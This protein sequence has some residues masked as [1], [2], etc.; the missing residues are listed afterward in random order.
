MRP[1]TA[2]PDVSEN[3]PAWSPD[4]LWIAYSATTD[5][6]GDLWLISPDGASARRLTN[7]PP[8]EDSPDWSP[9]G[10][11]IA[12]HATRE[13]RPPSIWILDLADSSVTQL[14]HERTRTLNPAWS[15]NGRAITYYGI[16]SGDEQV[17][18]IPV[19]GGPARRLS[20]HATQ[21]W[22]ADWSPNGEE[23]VFSGYRNSETGGSLFIMPEEGEGAQCEHARALTRRK[24]HRWDREPS[25]SPDGR[26]IAFT[27]Q[28]RSGNWDVWL[29]SADGVTETPVTS[30]PAFDR[31]PSWS[32]DSR[33]LVIQSD[34][35]GSDDLWIVD[36]SAWTA[37]APASPA[38]GAAAG[39]PG[40]PTLRR[41]TDSKDND[42]Q[43]R[44]S[45]DGREILFHSWRAG[46]R[47]LWVVPAEGGEPQRLPSGDGYDEHGA[48]SPNGRQIAFASYV[49]DAR[50]Q[51]IFVMARDGSTPPHPLVMH[52]GDDYHPCWSPDGRLITFVTGRGGMPDIWIAEA[53]RPAAE[54]P[55]IGGPSEDGYPSWFPRGD[56]VLFQ[57]TRGDGVMG[58][59][60]APVIGGVAGEPTPFLKDDRSARHP[61]IS[62]DGAAVAFV[63]ARGRSSR[64]FVAP[65]A[66]AV[67]G[68]PA[69]IPLPDSL[70]ASYPAFSPD[71]R[72][73]AFSAYGSRS[74]SIWVYTAPGGFA[75]YGETDQERD[76]PSRK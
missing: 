60:S 3:Q 50:D 10:G 20:H 63:R 34:R 64:L 54:R 66:G 45:P 48:W 74:S 6:G 43:P 46:V 35:A 37:A 32:P 29:V 24:D 30:A 62:P 19:D 31:Q 5:S 47:D 73:I 23:I 51:E 15:P 39:P 11:R 18:E 2:T 9:D 76:A 4:G 56:R 59:W 71:G 58:I 16:A 72:S 25:W 57:S 69:A 36:V 55:F 52:P 1:L 75:R 42:Y 22:N 65:V 12:F 28:D 21:S 49:G 8:L 61:A 26:W 53:D 17:W 33:S 14:T 38:S 70:A 27:A 68:P 7:D 67:P 41:L 40:G 44:W 13:G